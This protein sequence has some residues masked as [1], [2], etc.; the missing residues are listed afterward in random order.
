[1]PQAAEVV[2][3]RKSPVFKRLAALKARAARDLVLI[4]GPKLLEEALAAGVAIRD[5]LASTRAATRSR[6]TLL[7]AQARGI[8]VRLLDDALLDSLSEAETSQG[9]LALA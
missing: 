9:V 2:R 3:S 7:A 8:G 5:V 4:E 6:A 1:M